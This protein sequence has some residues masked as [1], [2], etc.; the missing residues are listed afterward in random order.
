MPAKTLKNLLN[1]SENGSLGEIVERARAMGELT[2]T[3]SNTLPSGLAGGIQA[4]VVNAAGE[5]VI[6][7][8]SSAWASRLRFEQGALLAAARGCG[9]DVDKVSVKVATID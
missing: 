1:S 8:R 3:L 7:S 6:F 4:A 9:L 5:L 2:E